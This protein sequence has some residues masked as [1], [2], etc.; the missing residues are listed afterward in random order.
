MSD[1]PVRET[2]DR[3]VS[4]V[5]AQG[6]HLFARIDHADHARKKG[7]ELRP[8]ELILFGNPEIGTRLM[9][10]RQVAAIDLPM[11]ALAWEGER[12]QVRIA[13]NT[14]AWLKQRHALAD[15]ATL[16]AIDEVLAKICA[17][18]RQSS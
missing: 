13:H 1:F 8:T 4:V 2:I 6:W 16:R 3:M 9:Q 12:G 5:E 7:L 11:K 14:M 10:D 17:S 15:E 18:V